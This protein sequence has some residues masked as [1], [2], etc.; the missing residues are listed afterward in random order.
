MKK[1]EIKFLKAYN[2]VLAA[3]L[4]MLG[5]GSCENRV[6]AEYGTPSATFIVQGIVES[7]DSDQPIKNIRVIMQG[8]TTFTDNNG[9]YKVMDMFGFPG[10]KTYYIQFQDIDGVQNGDYKD[11][12]SS[13]DFVD[14]EYTNGDGNWYSGEA[15][16]ALDVKMDPK[17]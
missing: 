16:E 7:S 3:L 8:D 13:V 10:D 4:A 9:Y 1:L 17:K 5:F 6:V 11:L 14:P 12:E 2:L 15:T